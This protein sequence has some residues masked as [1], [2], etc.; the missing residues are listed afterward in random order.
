VP[1]VHWFSL[2]LGPRAAD[3]RDA[4]P[5]RVEDLAPELDD[6]AETAAAITQVDLVLTADT[7]VAHLAGALGVPTWVMLPAS[8]DWRWLRAGERSPWYPSLRLFRQ[9]SDRSWAPVVDAVAGE[10]ARAVAGCPAR[11]ARPTQ[12]DSSVANS[13][14]L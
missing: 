14:S 2:Q 4:P 3:V 7:A 10:L 8:P 13:I 6:F 1:D 5:G 11:H 9:A 12:D